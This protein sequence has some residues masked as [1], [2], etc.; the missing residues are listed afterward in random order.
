MENEYVWDDKDKVIDQTKRVKKIWDTI[1]PETYPHIK[2][3]DTEGVKEVEHIQ[4]MGPYHMTERKIK[5]KV[6]VTLDS[7]PLKEIGWSENE[8]ISNEMITKAYGKDYFY[9]MRNSMRRLLSYVGLDKYS[10]FDF[11]GDIGGSVE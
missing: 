3:F 11:V 4:R 1:M 2:K 8:E 9:E 5:F 10:N 6:K 7:K